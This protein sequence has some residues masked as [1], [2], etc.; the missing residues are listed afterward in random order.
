MSALF[1]AMLPQH[2]PDERVDL[3]SWRPH[4]VVINLATNDYNPDHETPVDPGA[5]VAAYQG[6]TDYLAVHA[7]FGVVTSKRLT[8]CGAQS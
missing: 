7:L 4:A 2:N 6:G 3:T 5:F 1:D 8:N